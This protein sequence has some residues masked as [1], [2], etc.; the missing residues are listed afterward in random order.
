MYTP[1]RSG[2]FRVNPLFRVLLSVASRKIAL[3]LTINPRVGYF[4]E[5]TF[6]VMTCVSLDDYGVD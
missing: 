5:T 2:Y 3:P 1:K 6:W 4:G